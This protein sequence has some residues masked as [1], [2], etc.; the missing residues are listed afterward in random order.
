MV[1]KYEFTHERDYVN[2]RC[3]IL[4]LQDYCE[5]LEKEIEQLK[6]NKSGK[7]VTLWTNGNAFRKYQGQDKRHYPQTGWRKVKAI[8]YE[9]EE[10]K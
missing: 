10:N 4:D 2:M 7:E 3:H 1:E 9:I 6:N 8:I 5:K